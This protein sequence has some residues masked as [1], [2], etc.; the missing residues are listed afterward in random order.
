MCYCQVC[1]I[2]SQHV[3]V[4]EYRYSLN[5]YCDHCSDTVMPFSTKTVMPEPEGRK[6][7]K[8]RGR[9]GGVHENWE[10]KGEEHFRNGAMIQPMTFCQ[11]CELHW[12]PVWPC[13]FFTR[14]GIAT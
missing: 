13:M 8:E 11:R 5:F 4:Y 6:M 14:S 2:H 3:H 10:R 1:K 7:E 12:G 9:G